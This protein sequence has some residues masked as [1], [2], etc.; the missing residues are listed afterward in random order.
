[1]KENME[2]NGNFLKKIKEMKTEISWS[3]GNKQ[4]NMSRNCISIKELRVWR[5][6]AAVEGTCCSSRKPGFNSQHH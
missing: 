6:G 2:M 4:S 1:M 3:L 5:D